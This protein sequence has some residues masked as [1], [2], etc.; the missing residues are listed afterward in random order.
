MTIE[1][2]ITDVVGLLHRVAREYA[3]EATHDGV[4]AAMVQ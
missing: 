4:A 2:R 3:P 1:A